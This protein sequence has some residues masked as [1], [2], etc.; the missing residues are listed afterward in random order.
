LALLPSVDFAKLFSLKN[1][2]HDPYA[3]NLD[4]RHL[5]SV[6][7]SMNGW[8]KEYVV[9]HP[10]FRAV[11]QGVQDLRVSNFGSRW[12]WGGLASRPSPFALRGREFNILDMAKPRAGLNVVVWR[13]S[14]VP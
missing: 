1:I 12:K 7:F 6:H 2:L 9:H 13:N 11:D 4:M 3:L 10:E 14:S 8:S 5:K